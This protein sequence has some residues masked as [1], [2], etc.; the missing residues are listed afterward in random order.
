VLALYLPGGLKFDP[1]GSTHHRCSLSLKSSAGDAKQG[2][3]PLKRVHA[4]SGEGG[5]RAESRPMVRV[6][7]TTCESGQWV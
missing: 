2:D 7:C 4:E 1:P 3:L 6:S 5:A